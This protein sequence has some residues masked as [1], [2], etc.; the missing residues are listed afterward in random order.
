MAKARE[1]PERRLAKLIERYV[2]VETA[3]T[4]KDACESVGIKYDLYRRRMNEPW[5]LTVEE[6]QK[7]RRLGIPTE[8]LTEALSQAIGGPK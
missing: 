8:E 6:L 4:S 3:G 5:N 7:F 2:K 1:A